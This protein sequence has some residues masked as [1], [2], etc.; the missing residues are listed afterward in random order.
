MRFGEHKRLF[1]KTLKQSCRRQTFEFY[2][3]Y[4]HKRKMSVKKKRKIQVNKC[5]YFS[6]MFMNL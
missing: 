3:N 4:K 2:I 5:A 1:S 6:K